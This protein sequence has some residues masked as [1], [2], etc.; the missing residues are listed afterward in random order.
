MR[1]RSAARASRSRSAGPP[2]GVV[3]IRK[4]V[5]EIENPEGQVAAHHGNEG[6]AVEQGV[7]GEGFKR[8]LAPLAQPD[9]RRRQRVAQGE[10]QAIGAGQGCCTGHQA[11]GHR[12]PPGWPFDAEALERKVHQEAQQEHV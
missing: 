5:A 8:T 9:A 1:G 3:G 2:L 4:Q 7:P 10:H 12:K 6:P 11:E